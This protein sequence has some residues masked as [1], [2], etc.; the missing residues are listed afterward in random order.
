MKHKFAYALFAI[1]SLTAGFFGGRLGMAQTSAKTPAPA[2]WMTSQAWGWVSVPS[3]TDT[4]SPAKKYEIGIF[5]D[6]ANGN[7]VYVTE[8]GSIAVVH[9]AK[10]ASP[11]K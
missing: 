10:M 9:P 2:P 1:L 6:D 7:V 5:R 3:A 4:T 11:A 8:T